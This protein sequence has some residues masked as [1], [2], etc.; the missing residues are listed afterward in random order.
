MRFFFLFILS[1]TVYGKK[2]TLNQAVLDSPFKLASLGW[3]AFFPKENAIL[4]KG[5]GDKWKEWFKVDLI[6]NDTILFIDSLSFR[7]K[8]NDVFVN[9]LSFSKNGKMLLIGTDKRKLWR[10]S[11]TSTFFIYDI[12]NKKFF[13]VS[14]QNKMLRNV[15]FSPNSMY[16]SY[17]RQDNNIYIF[18]IKTKRERQLTRT[19]SETLSNGHFG[20]LYEEELT[21]YDGYRW[22]PD[23]E[24]ISFWEENEEMVPEFFMINEL[25]HYPSIKKIRYPKVGEINP[26]LRLGIIRI[27]GSGRKWIKGGRQIS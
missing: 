11:F 18:N 6:K 2:L 1:V 19:G 15:K 8:G 14:S 20:W 16:V 26:S 24:Y 3:H 4:I 12:V 7:W 13:P 25:N 21:G 17:V 5:Q 10:H 27:K 9:T 22:S 23:S